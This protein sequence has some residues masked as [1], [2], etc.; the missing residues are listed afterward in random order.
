MSS[1][2]IHDSIYPLINS[3]CLPET[4]G[5][6][7]VMA[8]IM[9]SSS[10]ING[11]WEDLEIMPYG[12][13]QMYPNSKVLHY[14]QEVFEGMKAYKVDGNGPFIFRPDENLKRFNRSA[15]RM[16]MPEVPQEIFMNSVLKLTELSEKYIPT[17][18]GQSLYIRPFMFATDEALGIRPSENY[19]YMVI[20]SPSESIFSAGDLNV[21]I[22]RDTARAYPGGTGFA[23]TGGNYSASLLSFYKAKKLGCAQTLWLDG[24]E[25]KYVEEMSGM[26]FFAVINNALYTP[27]ISDTILDGITRKSIIT[28]A[29]DYGMPVVEQK[30]EIEY[31]IKCIKSGECTEAFACGTAAI[32]NT[33]TALKE[34]NGEIYNLK[35]PK[36]TLGNRF[37]SQL[38][39]IQEGR[40]EDKFNWVTRVVVAK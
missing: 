19:R 26:N 30:L 18:T 8:P 21:L 10:Y 40:A 24:K 35:D 1:T 14:A 16:A 38:L 39:S 37:K 22:E 32:I 28:I 11:K 27:K 4:L 36:G 9:A 6:G 33:I 29:Q 15:I 25:K 2:K 20:A 12:P 17:K 5:F 7:L 31:L 3:F 13:I 34:E 23:K